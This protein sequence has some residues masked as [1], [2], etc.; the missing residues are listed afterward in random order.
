MKNAVKGHI[1]KGVAVCVVSTLC[2]AVLPSIYEA[3]QGIHEVSSRVE[4]VVHPIRA[5]CAFAKHH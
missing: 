1:I 2:H 4:R 5:V 3:D